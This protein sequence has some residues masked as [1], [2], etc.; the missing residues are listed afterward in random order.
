MIA[1]G[2]APASLPRGQRVYAIGDV[3]GCLDQLRALHQMIAEDLAARP[4]AS[5]TLVHLGDYVD[6]GPDSAGV[7][8]LLLE[9]PMPAGI[10]AVVNLIGNHEEMMLAALDDCSPPV[11]WHWLINGGEATLDSFGLADTPDPAVWAERLPG[12]R[13]AFLRG[14]ALTYHAG[15][16]FFVHAGARPGVPLAD[17]AREDLLW[18]REPFLSSVAPFEAVVV[19]GHTP[20]PVPELRRNRIGID[21]GAVMGGVLT[22]AVLERRKVGFIHA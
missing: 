21:T 5:S 15:D 9:G 20:V 17:Q 16:Y 11:V 3:H 2:P 22:C 18:I 4:I 13:L 7:V 6:R 14:L 8:S 1:F 19:H 10:G 12:E